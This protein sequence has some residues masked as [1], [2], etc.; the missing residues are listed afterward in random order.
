MKNYKF[1]LFTGMASIWTGVMLRLFGV[2]VPSPYLFFAAGAGFK[3]AYLYWAYRQGI[4]KPGLELVFLGAGL[5][6]LFLGIKVRLHD[7]GSIFGFMLI[8]KAVLMK[9]SFLFLVIRKLREARLQTAPVSVIDLD[10]NRAA[11]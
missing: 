10:G 4:Y 11:V 7:P 6:I 9:L 8:S 1:I 3:F 5:F 2:A